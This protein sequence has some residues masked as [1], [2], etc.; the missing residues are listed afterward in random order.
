M[1]II[2]VIDLKDGVVV[3]GVA[4]RRELYRPVESV[5]CRGAS[6]ESVAD[7]F[8]RHFGFESAYIADLD[9][10]TGA[11]P[12]WQAYEDV[13]SAGLRPIIDA[14]TTSVDRAAAFALHG[15]RWGGIVVGLESLV[16]ER[17]LAA[18][19]SEIRPD[20]AIFS[21][22]LRDG[23]PLTALPEWSNSPPIQIVDAVVDAGFRRVIVLDLLRVGVGEGVSVL[24][25][26][27]SVKSKYPQ[28]EITSGG[29]VRGSRDL[30]E[31]ASTGCDAA[32]VASALHNGNLSKAD[33]ARFR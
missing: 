18:L 4:G 32:L 33:L 17:D 6:P 1:N 28:L 26:C 30:E 10:I 22:D 24:E 29:G 15:S 19:L 20:G 31:L 5:L 25:L 23:R 12:N 16:S 8:V 21:L 7:A 2:P 27:A 9:A 13:V 11:E 14:G 3:R